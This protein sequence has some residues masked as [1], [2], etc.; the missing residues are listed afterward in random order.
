MPREQVEQWFDENQDTLDDFVKET[1]GDPEQALAHVAKN[2]RRCRATSR[3]MFLEWAV[4]LIAGQPGYGGSLAAIKALDLDVLSFFNQ[5]EQS[6]EYQPFETET[7]GTTQFVNMGQS[8]IWKLPTNQTVTIRHEQYS[9]GEVAERLWPCCLRN[10]GG[11]SLVMKKLK[12]QNIHVA[13]I[14]LAVRDDEMLKFQNGDTLDY[15]GCNP[16]VVSS[17]GG[18][19]AQAAQDKFERATLKRTSWNMDRVSFTVDEEGQNVRWPDK[20]EVP[21]GAGPDGGDSDWVTSNLRSGDYRSAGGQA[22]A[23][24][25]KLDYD[26]KGDP[27]ADIKINCDSQDLTLHAVLSDGDNTGR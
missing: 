4:K 19:A 20:P 6:Y 15:T 8:K 7:H 27:F 3:D 26:E 5:A 13:R 22:V 21:K 1:A 25:P 10:V 17:R 18:I 16:Y 23:V 9:W 11:L 14:L 24:A 2:L 12:G